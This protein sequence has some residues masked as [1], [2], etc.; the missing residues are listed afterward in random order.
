M[1]KNTAL[2]KDSSAK[3]L[4]QSLNVRFQGWIDAAQ[5]QAGNAAAP[6]SNPQPASGIPPSQLVSPVSDW[7]KKLDDDNKDNDCPLNTRLFLDLPGYLKALPRSDD[8]N[9]VFSGLNDAAKKIVTAQDVIIG[10]MKQQ[11]IR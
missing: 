11:A 7:L 5:A 6:S 4:Y 2:I 8:P 3:S 1:Q 10:M 9:V